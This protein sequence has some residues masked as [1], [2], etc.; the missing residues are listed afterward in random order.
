MAKA[1]V[2]LIC[3]ECGTEFK[4][5][6]F[7]G[8]RSEANSW[9]EYMSGRTNCTCYTC[10]TKAKQAKAEAEKQ[11]F[12][13]TFYSKQ[14]LPQIEGVSEKQIKY[15]EDLRIKFVYAAVKRELI[16]PIQREAEISK[17]TRTE[18]NAGK[19][20]DTLKEVL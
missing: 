10:Y 16:L 19:I 15:A 8:K 4:R 18:T 1:V 7:F 9:E 17:F 12:V 6:K 20:I 3:A 2:R 13:E 11:E 5:E 14:N